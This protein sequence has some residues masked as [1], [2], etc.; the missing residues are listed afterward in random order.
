MIISKDKNLFY[1]LLGN[2][3][4]FICKL[5]NQVFLN[6]QMVIYR[7]SL[8]SS[9][10]LF[11]KIGATQFF[12]SKYVYVGTC[13]G[14][15]MKSTLLNQEPIHSSPQN[16]FISLYPC[17]DSAYTVTKYFYLRLCWGRLDGKTDSIYPFLLFLCK[18]A[19]WS[20]AI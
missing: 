11:C 4:I 19:Y 8:S 1:L 2:L 16:H 10:P 13:L 3:L 20:I 18:A 5:T 17:S 7:D 12:F 14:D 9:L 15:S 6:I